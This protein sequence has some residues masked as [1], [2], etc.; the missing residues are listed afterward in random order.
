VLRNRRTPD[1]AWITETDEGRK[2]FVNLLPVGGGA[3][4]EGYLLRIDQS[5]RQT[6]GADF[7]GLAIRT[8]SVSLAHA[9]PLAAL[10]TMIRMR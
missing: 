6:F 9:D 8:F 2:T 7:R 4:V 1:L 3:A 5:L 10:V